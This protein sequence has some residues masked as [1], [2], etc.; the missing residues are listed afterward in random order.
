MS[1]VI[2]CIIIATFVLSRALLVQTAFGVK[3]LTN[4]A[5]MFFIPVWIIEGGGSGVF[6][7]F[8]ARIE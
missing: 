6:A 5:D 8:G 7:K 1:S 4:F 3:L 2:F